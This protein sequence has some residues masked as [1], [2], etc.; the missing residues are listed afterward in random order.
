MAKKRSRNLVGLIVSMAVATAAPPLG[1]VVSVLFL[2]RGFEET[3]KVDASQKAT[4]LANR[5]S[6]AMNGAAFG[7]IVSF[8]A[9][10]AA[11]VFA[12]RL[13]RERRTAHG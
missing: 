1:S 2:S 8:V 6:E 5:I 7:L 10:A 13:I 11:V 3:A 4:V 9:T 12:V